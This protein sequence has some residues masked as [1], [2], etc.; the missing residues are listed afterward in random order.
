MKTSSK[1]NLVAA[2]IGIIYFIF[3]IIPLLKG[4][5]GKNTVYNT[6]STEWVEEPMMIE[7]A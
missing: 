7:E 1:I 4:I 6:T 2:I 5:F 3:S